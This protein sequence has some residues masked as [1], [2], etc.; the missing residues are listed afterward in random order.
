MINSALSVSTVLQL[1]KKILACRSQTVLLCIIEEIRQLLNC[2]KIHIVTFNT[3]EK[4][5]LCYHDKLISE[6]PE[7]SNKKFCHLQYLKNISAMDTATDTATN[8]PHGISPV[9]SSDKKI[10]GINCIASVVEHFDTCLLAIFTFGKTLNQD[11]ESSLE[12]FFEALKNIHFELQMNLNLTKREGDIFAMLAQGNAI[13]DIANHY[14]ISVRTVKFHLQNIY[15]KLNVSNMTE[16][17][18]VKNKI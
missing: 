1:H 15:R 14:D 16:A 12:L 18:V 8:M 5:T 6:G 7:L 2:Q 10:E 9:L 4:G 13:I 17:L 3:D 11:E